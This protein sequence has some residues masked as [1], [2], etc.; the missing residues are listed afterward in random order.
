LLWSRHRGYSN[1]INN[2]NG[3]VFQKLL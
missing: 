2:S 3:T 1:S